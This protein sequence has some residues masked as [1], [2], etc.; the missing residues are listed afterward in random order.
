[1]LDYL[2]HLNELILKRNSEDH[3]QQINIEKIP[4]IFLLGNKIDMERYRQ[5][6]KQEVEDV[7]AKY[8]ANI[9][10]LTHL[11][12]TSCEE[13]E[14]VQSLI[15]KI[16]RETRKEREVMSN[17]DVNK[18]KSHSKRSKSP[19]STTNMLV[20]DTSLSSSN[21]R[22]NSKFPFFNILTKK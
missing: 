16:V 20:R 3:Q 8:S 22:N 10:N 2:E 13:H 12:T 5:V 19:K 1:M 11:E 15:Y 9:K 21:Q 4:K 6:S 17:V 14:L 18:S 7:L